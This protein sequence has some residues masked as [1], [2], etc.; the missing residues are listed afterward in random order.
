[1]RVVRYDICGMTHAGQKGRNEDAYAVIEIADAS[2]LAVADGVGGEVHGDRAAQIAIESVTA[3]FT[4]TYR[5]GMERGEIKDLLASA[6]AE[7]D[8]RIRETAKSEGRMGTTLVAAIITNR[9]VVIANCGDSR[10]FVTGTGMRFRTREHTLVQML[11][12]QG[13]ID[14]AEARHHPL[15]NVIV[16][17]LG[18]TMTV[19]LYEE[20]LR[21]GEILVLC[22]DGLPDEAAREIL[23]SGAERGSEEIARELLQGGIARSDDDV[24]VVVLKE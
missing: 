8:L 6:F 9:C 1:M 24:T 18:I 17:A 16:H 10:A 13:S 20:D 22:S 5:R 4:G 11:L 14:A 21:P 7:A 15:R 23:S 12:E 19:D 3:A 2:L